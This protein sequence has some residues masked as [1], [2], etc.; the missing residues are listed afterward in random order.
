M[1]RRHLLLV[2]ILLST[3]MINAQNKAG[4]FIGYE[5]VSE[6]TSDSEKNAATWFKQNYSDGI[7]FTPSMINTL[8]ASNVKVLWVMIDRVGIEK[9][10]KNLPSAF[11]DD[12]TINTLKTD[13]KSVV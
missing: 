3:L 1:I 11:K 7:V 6:I 8:S 5:D 4:L 12:Q 13:R 9:G 10:W 2:V